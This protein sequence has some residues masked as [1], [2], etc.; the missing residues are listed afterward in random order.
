MTSDTANLSRPPAELAEGS[1]IPETTLADLLRGLLAL[2]GIRRDMLSGLRSQHE[3][4]GPVVAQRGSKGRFVHCF[5]ADANRFVL[6]DSN[7]LFSARLPWMGIMG[8]IFPNGL[9][10]MDGPQHAH[11]RRMMHG[12]FTKQALRTYV[13]GMNEMIEQTLDQWAAGP[14]RVRMYPMLKR[15]TLE[16]AAKIFLG[17]ELGPEISRINR[18]FEHMVAASMSRLRVRLPG[19]EFHRGI[20]GRQLMQDFLRARI[21]ARREGEGTDLF[22]RVCRAR[23]PEGQQ[24]GD[25]EILDHMTFLMMAAHDTTT[26][27]L[28]SLAFELAKHPEWQDRIRDES[29]ALRRAHADIDAVDG[30]ESMTLAMRETLRRYPP[31][32]VI[33]RVATADFEWC[34]HRIRAGTMV[35]LSPIH[36]HHMEAYWS[37]PF[38]FDPERFS[39]ARA[40]DSVHSHAWVPFGGGS[41]VCL[42]KRFAE[43]QIHAVLHQLL[44][45][46]RLKVPAGYVMPVQQAPISKPTDGLPL[47]L[48]AA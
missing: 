20:Q 10:L 21:A 43:I 30:L 46:F 24:L 4:F 40:E 27:T 47:E 9:L 16:I 5:G 7:K 12:T 26:S 36:T 44:L 13:D 18:A 34:G 31:L 8:Q 32:P 2:G 29:R 41:H 37:E 19:F 28:T 45:R 39:P 38:R 3:R 25:Q 17:V 1:P 48:C 6:L 14:S 42:G 15:M 35:V 33:P 22:S 23:D 11:D